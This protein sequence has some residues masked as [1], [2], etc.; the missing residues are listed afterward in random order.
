MCEI[1]K[2]YDGFS[3]VCTNVQGESL[4]FV[5]EL[6]GV[7][8]QKGALSIHD[9]TKVAPTE[10]SQ[11]TV[12]LDGSWQTRGL[13]S[14]DGVVTYMYGN[15]CIDYDVCSKHCMG[16]LEVAVASAV[17]TI[18]DGQVPIVY[19]LERMNLKSGARLEQG[20]VKSSSKCARQ[21]T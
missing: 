12:S 2:G 13:S 20:F 17:C 10:I 16:T 4:R 14:I 3:K 5:L 15:K 21:S 7:S 18:N 8:L 9:A 6:D 1:G 11:C 19:V